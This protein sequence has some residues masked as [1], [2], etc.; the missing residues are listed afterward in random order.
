MWYDFTPPHDYPSGITRGVAYAESS[1][2]L[3]WEKP[4]LGL[5]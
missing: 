5:V 2:G 3:N 1:D 4:E